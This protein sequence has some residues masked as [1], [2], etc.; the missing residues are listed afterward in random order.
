[1]ERERERE[2]GWGE[3]ERDGK[4]EVCSGSDNKNVV[5]KSVQE[6]TALYGHEMQTVAHLHMHIIIHVTNNNK[7]I[8]NLYKDTS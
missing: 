7:L 1:M 2:R 6:Q 4:M 3:K 5:T 8:F